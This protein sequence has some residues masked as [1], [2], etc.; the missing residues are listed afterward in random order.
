[1]TIG[2][3]VL[4]LYLMSGGLIGALAMRGPEF[5]FESRL[6]TFIFH[7]TLTPLLIFMVFCAWVLLWP[8]T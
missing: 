5:L 3:V 6:T 7:L 4:V 1:M 2:Y 8:F